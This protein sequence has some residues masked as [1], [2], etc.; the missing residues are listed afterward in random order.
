MSERV[1]K[2][3]DWPPIVGKNIVVK[4]SN[5]KVFTGKVYKNIWNNTAS[6]IELTNNKDY[7]EPTVVSEKLIEGS[8]GK[9]YFLALPTHAWYYEPGKK[10]KS[11]ISKEEI[12]K[13]IEEFLEKETDLDLNDGTDIIEKLYSRKKKKEEDDK[14]YIEGGEEFEQNENEEINLNNITTLTE[15]DINKEL[16][17]SSK[18]QEL[19]AATRKQ[20]SDELFELKEIQPNDAMYVVNVT[21]AVKNLIKNKEDELNEG[22]KIINWIIKNLMEKENSYFKDLKMSIYN[23]YVHVSRKGIPVEDKITRDLVPGLTHFKWQYDVPIDY[24]T[25]KYVLF[26]NDIQKNIDMNKREQ[27]EAD[28]ILSQ[29]YLI[30]LTPEPKYQI[31]C[32]KRLLMCWYGDIDLQNNIRKIKILINQWRSF[33]NKKYNIKNGILPSIVIYPKYGKSIAK[34]VL[35]KIGSYFIYYSNIGWKCTA[36]S[37]FIR[38]NDILWYTNGSIDL[39]MYFRKV[40][41]GYGSTVKDK[42]FNDKYTMLEGADKII[43]DVKK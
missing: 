5:G 29:E 23:G 28:E 36:P 39:K 21:L 25:L 38:V 43:L 20:I 8:N 31:W 41:D 30:A 19:D 34:M 10:T 15:H 2:N 18:L 1:D 42:T 32:L 13:K 6:L 11:D 22:R 17:D 3:P 33:S 37:Y 27:I 16:A 12:F 35:M 14:C 9:G 26:Q 4:N 40:K 24:D 7:I